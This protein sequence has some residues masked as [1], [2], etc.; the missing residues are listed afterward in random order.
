M[1]KIIYRYQLTILLL[2]SSLSQD[3]IVDLMNL[4]FA[5]SPYP[6]KDFIHGD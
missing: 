2:Q 4:S 3:E 1:S 6:L 5:I